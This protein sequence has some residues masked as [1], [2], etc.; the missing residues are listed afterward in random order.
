MAIL[1]RRSRRRGR[2]E[3]IQ[4]KEAHQYDGQ[5]SCVRLPPR[6]RASRARSAPRRQEARRPRR[7]CRRR[8]NLEGLTDNVQ[9]GGQNSHR[10]CATSPQVER[11]PSRAATCV[12]QDTVEV[13]GE[14]LELKEHHQPPMVDQLNAFASE[15]DARRREGGTKASSAG[16]RRCLGSPEPEG[17]TD[18]VNS[19]AGKLTSQ[20]RNIAEGPTAHAGGDLSKTITVE[21]QRRNFSGRKPQHDG[22]SAQRLR[23]R[24]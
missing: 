12:A 5:I 21:R 14:V 11:P 4:L 13:K 1:S 20:V 15:A 8:R 23:R 22:G 9:C 10:R 18:S 6:C 19:M 24:S 16:Q 7:S 17:P 2:G 3:I